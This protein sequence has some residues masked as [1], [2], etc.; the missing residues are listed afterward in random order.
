[1]YHPPDY[2]DNV[3]AERQLKQ[4]LNAL[5]AEWKETHLDIASG[6]FEP[7]VWAHVGDTFRTLDGLRLL[8]GRAPDLDTDERADGAIDLRA[9]YRDKLR[10]NLDALPLDRSR[11]ALIDD[12]IAF[13]QR[14]SVQVRY[15]TRSFLHAKAY[16]LG[17]VAIVGSSNFTPSGM[18]RRAELNLVSKQDAAVRDLR[19]Q[20]FELMWGESDDHKADLIAAPRREQV[21]QGQLDT[22]RRLHQGALRVLQRPSAARYARPCARRGAGLV[23]AGGPA[24]SRA[25][26]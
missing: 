25:P 11:A 15:Y 8:L 23:P 17:N 2:I 9:F 20:W 7:E 5:I 22:L 16:L 18:T 3:T 14:E 19:E 26:D 13:L 12:L 21:R 6:F 24:R 4:V 10:E 1:M